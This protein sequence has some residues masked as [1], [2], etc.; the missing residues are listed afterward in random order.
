MDKETLDKVLAVLSKH[1]IDDEVIGEVETELND[2]KTPTDTPTDD[3]DEKDSKPTPDPVD[4]EGE[5]ETK[6]KEDDPK[7]DEGDTD[8]GGKNLPKGIDEVDLSKDAPIVD[9]GDAEVDQPLPPLPQQPEVDQPQVDDVATAIP[10]EK[11]AKINELQKS[12]EGLIK[13][14]DALEDALRKG[15]IL[16][17]E[18]LT[19][20]NQPYGV[21]N[22]THISDN[23][24]D[25]E[26]FDNVL[27]EINKRH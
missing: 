10:D 12:N 23:R 18:P 15:G 24:D 6:D 25:D 17:D 13:R 2:D 5:G 22:P 4:A 26:L 1:G 27:A 3:K 14:I 9:D 7:T 19:D 11:D 20:N 16:H 8:E 21:D